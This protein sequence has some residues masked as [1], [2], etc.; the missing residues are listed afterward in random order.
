MRGEA[1]SAEGG[2]GLKT[3]GFVPVDHAA[4]LTAGAGCEFPQQIAVFLR[5]IAA[6]FS[7]VQPVEG[8]LQFSVGIC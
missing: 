8:F 6:R 5:E 4:E 7:G 1:G 2:R 3:E